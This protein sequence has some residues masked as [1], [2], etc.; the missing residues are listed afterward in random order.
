MKKVKVEISAEIE[1]HYDENSQ[2][3]KNAFEGYKIIFGETNYIDDMLEN[4]THI[5]AKHGCEELI[6]GCGYVSVNGRK[7]F[8]YST[9][10]FKDWCGVDV[11]GSIDLND[12]IDYDIEIKEV[13]E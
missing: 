4:I 3:F 7:Q 6:E 10:G 11:V 2:E 8:D 13:E 1:L 5:I 9:G 12:T